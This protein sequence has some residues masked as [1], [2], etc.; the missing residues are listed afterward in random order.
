MKPGFLQLLGL[1]LLLRL[2]EQGVYLDLV[3]PWPLFGIG[4]SIV[5]ALGILIAVIVLL[6]YLALRGVKDT[7]SRK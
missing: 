3:P 2:P 7:Y 5:V 6:A 1:I 4:L